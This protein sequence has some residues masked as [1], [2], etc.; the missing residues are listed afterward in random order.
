M[1]IKRG[2]SIRAWLKRVEQEIV[3]ASEP[4]EDK[5]WLGRKQAVRPDWLGRPAKRG[6]DWLGRK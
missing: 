5:D 6:K 3:A 1:Q 4:A 2:E